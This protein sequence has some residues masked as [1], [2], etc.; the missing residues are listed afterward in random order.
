MTV[1]K[2]VHRIKCNPQSSFS[3][4]RNYTESKI[5]KNEKK[6]WIDAAK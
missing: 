1:P 3:L 6:M 4:L 5:E 2:Y